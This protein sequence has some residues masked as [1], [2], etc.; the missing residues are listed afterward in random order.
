MVAAQRGDQPARRP[1]AR[2]GG[3]AA[4]AGY[5]D[6]HDHQ[7]PIL[8]G[9]RGPFYQCSEA[10]HRE[11]R[12]AAVMPAPDGWWDT[13]EPADAGPPGGGPATGSV[14]DGLAFA[15]DDGLSLPPGGHAEGGGNDA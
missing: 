7:L 3:T 11:P 13:D 10:A 9:T 15:P 1:V 2:L 12:E 5:R 14:L 4:P 6:H 8:M